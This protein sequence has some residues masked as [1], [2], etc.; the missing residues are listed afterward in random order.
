MKQRIDIRA[1]GLS[2]TE[3]TKPVM[4]VVKNDSIPARDHIEIKVTKEGVIIE[5][6]DDV[7]NRFVHAYGLTFDED[8]QDKDERSGQTELNRG[9]VTGQASRTSDPVGDATC[10][11]AWIDLAKTNAHWR[12]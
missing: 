1:D 9:A 11:R 2:F 10:L 4:L 8:F 6:S 5:R 12:N 7:N 3:T